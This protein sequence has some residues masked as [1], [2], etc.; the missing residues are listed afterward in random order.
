[1][2]GYVGWL[3]K[4]RTNIK[5][6]ERARLDYWHPKGYAMRSWIAAGA[7]PYQIRTERRSLRRTTRGFA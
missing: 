5:A 2:D 7:P 4:R 3:A 1:L 6:P